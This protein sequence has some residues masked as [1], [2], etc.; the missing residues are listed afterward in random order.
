[1]HSFLLTIRSVLTHFV[2]KCLIMARS[3]TSN[4]MA[5]SKVKMEGFCEEKYSDLGDVAEATQTLTGENHK[6]RLLYS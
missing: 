6:V 2:S 1:M 4:N 3:L 5:D